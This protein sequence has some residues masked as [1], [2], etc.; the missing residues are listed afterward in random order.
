MNFISADFKNFEQLHEAAMHWE[1]D[2]R[3]LSKNDFQAHLSLF[4]SKNIQIGRT[5]LNGKIEQN[6]LTPKG[7][8]TIVIPV[9][10]K[11][12]YTWLQKEVDGEDILIFPE[13]GVLDSISFY[14][15]DVYVISVETSMLMHRLD[16]L[17]YKKAT[18]LFGK[19][20]RVIQTNRVFL[21]KIVSRLNHY[22]KHNSQWQTFRIGT[23]DQENFIMEEIL[24]MLFYHLENGRELKEYKVPR[25]KDKA[26]LEAV[27]LIKLNMEGSLNILSLCKEINIS[28]RTLEYG[29]LEKFKVTPKEYLKAQK[30][31]LVRRDI[32]SEEFRK[33]PIFQIAAKYGFW[34]MGQLAADFKKHFGVL[35]SD[36]R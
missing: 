16:F 10:P 11:V 21:N 7:F 30:L 24:D 17:E 22:M 13:N 19:E 12:Q 15:F 6:G 32:L 8:R 1:L 20:E 27:E 34:H 5:A 26:V 18:G 33:E 31:N 25:R 23:P 3:L 14:N 35:P 36:L 29:F 9:N 28:Q 4:T 2:F